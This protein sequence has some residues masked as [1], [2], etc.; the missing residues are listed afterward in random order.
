MIEKVTGIR[1]KIINALFILPALMI[2]FAVEI[3]FKIKFLSSNRILFLGKKKPVS[4]FLGQ[5]FLNIV[6]DSYLINV[7]Y[8][9]AAAMAG[10][11]RKSISSPTT[12]SSMP[13][14]SVSHPPIPPP[15][16]EV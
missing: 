2:C 7:N 15:G 5:V 10:L 11:E 14:T 9:P 12:V 1:I 13:N 8:F 4:I 3:V 16:D 6:I